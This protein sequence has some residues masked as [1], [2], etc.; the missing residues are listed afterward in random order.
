VPLVLAVTVAIAVA[1]VTVAR[2]LRGFRSDTRSYDDYVGDIRAMNEYN[3]YY[4][5]A[6]VIFLG[7]AIEGDVVSDRALIVLVMAFLAGSLSIFFFPI[8][9][10][11]PGASTARVRGYWLFKVIATQ[12]TVIL[13]VFGI[14]TVVAERVAQS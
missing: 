5:A 4:V 12:W 1:A 2:V 11:Q 10:T 6:I 13:T 3:S 8:Q 14:A 9:R 7:F